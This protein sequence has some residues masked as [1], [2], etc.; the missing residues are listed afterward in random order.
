VALLAKK[1]EIRGAATASVRVALQLMRIK[2]SQFEF[3]RIKQSRLIEA[4]RSYG[5]HWMLSE[6]RAALEICELTRLSYWVARPGFQ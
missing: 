6:M 3:Y 4:S 5:E 2:L 1:L